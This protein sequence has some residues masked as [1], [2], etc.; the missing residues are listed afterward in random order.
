MDME[1]LAASPHVIDALVEQKFRAVAV[2]AGDCTGVAIS[3][4]GELRIWGTFR[5]SYIA[6]KLPIH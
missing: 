1:E 4:K 2:E 5:V 3:D 6:A